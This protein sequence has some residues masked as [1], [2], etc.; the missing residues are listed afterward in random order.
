VAFGFLSIDFEQDQRS[1]LSICD[2]EFLS[3]MHHMIQ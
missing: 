3:P 2:G 1:M